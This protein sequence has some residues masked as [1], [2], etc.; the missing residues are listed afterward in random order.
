MTSPLGAQFAAEERGGHCYRL[1]GRHLLDFPNHVGTLVHGRAGGVNHAWVD[2]GP[3]GIYEPETNRHYSYADFQRSFS[4]QE[5]ARY[6]LEAAMTKMVRE[7]HWG[8]W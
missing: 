2:E 3:I 8:P 4:P 5:D 6:P 7:G 1:A